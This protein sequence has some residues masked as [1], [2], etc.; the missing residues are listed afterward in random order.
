MKQKSQFE[1]SDLHKTIELVSIDTAARE[2]DCS[3][4]TLKKYMRQDKLK[5]LKFRDHHVMLERKEWEQWK[6]QNIK[7]M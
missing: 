1:V 4:E 3:I 5:G 7:A 6:K 2:I